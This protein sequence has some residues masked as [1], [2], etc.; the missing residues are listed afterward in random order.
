ML[1]TLSVCELDIE[2]LLKIGWKVGIGGTVELPI[3]FSICMGMFSKIFSSFSCP[4]REQSVTAWAGVGYW[5]VRIN[6]FNCARSS[7]AASSSGRSLKFGL[8]PDKC[9]K[10]TLEILRFRDAESLCAYEFIDSVFLCPDTP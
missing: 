9:L 7:V 1:L 6:L 4:T 8:V 2:Q 10:I 5:F 3:P